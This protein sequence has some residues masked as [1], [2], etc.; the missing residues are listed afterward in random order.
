MNLALTVIAILAVLV[1]VAFFTL[2]RMGSR[3]TPDALRPGHP[4]PAFAARTENGDTVQSESLRGRPA[5]LL[6]VRGNWCPFCSKQVAD[7]TKYYKEIAD[8]GAKL[9]LVTPKP[10]E[11]TRR[12]AEFFDV[13][14]EFW[15]DEDLAAASRVGLALRGGVPKEHRADYGDDT[16]WPAAVVIDRDGQI[17]YTSVSKFIADRPNPRK[18]MQVLNSL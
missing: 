12:V 8:G 5:V 6:F 13:E 4:L 1:A 7:L 17:R 2:R 9:V 3:G 15:L 10:L 14:F 16:L 11:T 18:L